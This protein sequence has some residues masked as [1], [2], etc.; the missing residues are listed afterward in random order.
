VNATANTTAGGAA[1][2]VAPRRHRP[3]RRPS[4]RRLGAL[5]L[6]VLGFAIAILLWHVVAKRN[7]LT[8]PTPQA[9]WDD[10]RDNFRDSVYL[11]A[12]GLG[13]G[14]WDDLVYS[15]RNVVVGVLLGTAIGVTLGLVSVPLPVL[16]QILN[17][18]AATFGAAPIFVA[19]PFFLV[20]F[21]VV[22]TAQVLM[23]TFYT[24]L[25]L[26]IFSRRA[27][28]N[29]PSDLV[30][31]AA[32]LG[33]RRVDVFWR[34][35]VPGTVPELLGGFR[36]ALAGAWGLEAIAELLGAQ[37]GI[38]FLINYYAEVYVIVGMVSLTLLLGCVAVVCDG[39]AVLAGR[40]LVRW[41]AT[42]QVV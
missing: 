16:S 21:G 12:H 41:T 8:V 42:G 29:V 6:Q 15:T 33:A 26:Y 4:R 38:G 35:Y 36:I 23:V 37:H 31:S 27:A 24:S 17:P 32:T 9:T 40:M 5:A 28:E 1:E 30:E 19:A 25:L 14:Y 34:I 7:P 22:S 3:A 39:I 18:I 13:N 20:W 10:V 2:L 11:Q